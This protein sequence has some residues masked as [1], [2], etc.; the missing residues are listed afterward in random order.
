MVTD[1]LFS[2][3]NKNVLVSGASRG[4][5]EAIA[6]GFSS[7]GAN[8]LITSRNISSLKKVLSKNISNGKAMEAKACDISNEKHIKHLADYIQDK[9]GHPDILI[10]VAGIS[11]SRKSIENFTPVEYDNI[12]NINL[13]GCFM[14]SQAIGRLMIANR[15]GNIINIDSLNTYAPLKGVGPY[16]I[17]KAGIQMMTKSQALE[18]GQYNIRVNS[19]A[20]GFFPTVLT[21][22]TWK[23][24]YMVEWATN[25]TPLG[26]LGDLEDLIGAA[27]FLGSDA[28]QFITGQT[29]RVDGGISSGI[30]WPLKF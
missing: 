17:S 15:S 14:L 4:I 9:W 20:P 8:V 5:G 16:A 13:R 28:S 24:D 3:E 12:I 26:K 29:I 27:V 19:I 10:N 21:G 18:W 6:R 7:R 30:A 25:N 2:V 1:P 11:P 22:E 23:K